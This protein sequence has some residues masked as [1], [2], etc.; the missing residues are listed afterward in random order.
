MMVWRTKGEAGQNQ[1]TVT[2]FFIQS[3]W[4]IFCPE[5][6]HRE[7]QLSNLT[8]EVMRFGR[9]SREN[10]KAAG[11]HPLTEQWL[12]SFLVLTLTSTP[13]F[14]MQQDKDAEQGATGGQKSAVLTSAP[15]LFPLRTPQISQVGSLGLYDDSL[16]SHWHSHW[17]MWEI[18]H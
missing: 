6:L 4:L 9:N 18:W 17:L 1:V 12:C 15:R 13:K 16:Y 3:M 11:I 10:E 5:K 14:M 2:E 7:M 8:A